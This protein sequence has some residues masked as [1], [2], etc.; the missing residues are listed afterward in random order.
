MAA[1]AP[2]DRKG[3]WNFRVTRWGIGRAERVSRPTI[4]LNSNRS[5]QKFSPGCIVSVKTGF[6]FSH[7]QAPSFT[8]RG[9]AVNDHFA[10]EGPARH[11]AVGGDGVGM[12]PTARLS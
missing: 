1:F 8:P 10:V 2:R 4:R 9:P 6:P 7:L 12:Q 3:E 5:Y 11:S